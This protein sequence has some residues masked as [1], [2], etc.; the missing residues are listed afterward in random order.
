MGRGA[1]VDCR[2]GRVQLCA[3]RLADLDGPSVVEDTVVAVLKHQVDA[4]RLEREQVSVRDVELVREH[5]PLACL[6]VAGA[7]GA[8]LEQH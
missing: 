8:R 7:V 6:N 1:A 4:R 5:L 3:A 2:I